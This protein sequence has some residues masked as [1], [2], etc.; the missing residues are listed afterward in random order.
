MDQSFPQDSTFKGFSPG[1]MVFDR[2]ELEKMVGRGGMGVVWKA[3]DTRLDQTVALKF[4]PD[5]LFWDKLARQ[6]IT[7]ETRKARL[8]THPHIVRIHDLFED[9]QHAAICME[10]VEGADLNALKSERESKVL[11][12]AEIEP[13]LS[14]IID[15]MDY[16]HREVGMVHRDLKPANI[17]ITARGQA[18][19]SDFGVARSIAETMTR[20]S[21][22]SGAGT[23]AFMS[24]Q[25]FDGDPPTVADDW[26]AL[27]ATLYDLI[28]GKPPFFRGAVS[29]QIR[30]RNP[31]SMRARRTQ[32]GVAGDEIPDRWEKLVSV[33]LSKEPEK[34]PTSAD[35][36]RALLESDV[37]D[38]TDVSAGPGRRPRT[39]LLVG[40]ACLALAVLTGVLWNFQSSRAS[41]GADPARVGVSDVGGNADLSNN[42]ELAS[43][44]IGVAEG[45]VVLN[46]PLSQSVEDVGPFGIPVEL[47]GAELVPAQEGSGVRFDGFGFLQTAASP[48]LAFTKES[49]FRV[50]F[51]L[52]PELDESVGKQILFGLEREQVG[53]FFLQVSRMGRDVYILGS[54]AQIA[55]RL[56]I[57]ARGVLRE[58]DWQRMVIDCA[59]GEL[60]LTIDGTVVGHAKSELSSELSNEPAH[61]RIGSAFDQRQG[62]IGVLK[63]FRWEK[64]PESPMPR[65]RTLVQT[66]MGEIPL[67]DV[68][69]PFA[70]LEGFSAET[71]DLEE[72]VATQL[73]PAVRLAD[74]SDF[75]PWLEAQPDPVETLDRLGLA[76][77]NNAY[78][79]RDGER[80]TDDERHYFVTRMNGVIPDYYL[81]HDVAEENLVTLG[82]WHGIHMPL[83]VQTREEA[84][85]LPT[86]EQLNFVDPDRSPA[87]WWVKGDQSRISERDDGVEIAAGETSIVIERSLAGALNREQMSIAVRYQMGVSPWGASFSL[88]YRYADESRSYLKAEILDAQNGVQAFALSAGGGRT[89]RREIAHRL[90]AQ[91]MVFFY[92][93]DRI[94]GVVRKLVDREE[95]FTATENLPVRPDDPVAVGIEIDLPAGAPVNIEWVKFRA[96]L[97]TEISQE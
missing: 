61:V 57:L 11:E 82:S 33:C 20:V 93:S 1:M 59:N 19:I 68:G 74:W 84:V 66:N 12:P 35:G 92:T 43:S 80:W 14:D 34:R 49:A 29:E 37:D 7:E 75:K 90:D 87:W 73:G 78:V 69:A 65:L 5:V 83:L 3:K 24:P 71:E 8:L 9:D 67:T 45:E 54:H 85:F 16:A 10:F 22:F 32:L 31:E 4:L 79:S 70:L 53:E 56:Q 30:S 95:L 23:L 25:Q 97:G 42:R 50:S 28:T 58:G 88:Y 26:Y 48:Q 38:E 41:D 52:L 64:L 91:E 46:L 13:W 62:F 81:A 72:I 60:A 51:D 63:N 89:S 55:E 15:A 76:F 86:E 21:T 40:G 36:V 17:L 47:Q 77:Q 94:R 44:A 2:F 18:K 39:G 6:Q 27:G 96:A